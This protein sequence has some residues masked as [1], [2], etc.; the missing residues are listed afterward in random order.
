MDQ[1]HKAIENDNISQV[2]LLLEP[3]PTILLCN[4]ENG[5]SALDLAYR[6]GNSSIIGICK[7]FAALGLSA[8]KNN[9]KIS[10]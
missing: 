5:I 9:M 7:E 4:N 1:L 10:M 3:N 6:F 2:R 8:P